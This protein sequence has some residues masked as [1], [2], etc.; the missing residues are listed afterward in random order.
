MIQVSLYR[1]TNCHH[2]H[3]DHYGDDDD[4][5]IASSRKAGIFPVSSCRNNQ[6][7][8]KCLI[9]KMYSCWTRK[10]EEKGSWG[11]GEEGW[12]WIRSK[13]VLCVY[14]HATMKLII[15]YD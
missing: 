2:Y 14:E 12:M 6:R 13:Y 11:R 9:Y 4:Y 3:H 1:D 15:L 5:L 8:E 10:D 7:L